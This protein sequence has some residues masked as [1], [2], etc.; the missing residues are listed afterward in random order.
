MDSTSKIFYNTE[1]KSSHPAKLYF[2]FI[3]SIRMR[4]V[5]I[6]WLEVDVRKLNFLWYWSNDVFKLTVV[7]DEA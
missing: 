6:D 3:L 5:A 7:N 2:G 4:Y 1:R